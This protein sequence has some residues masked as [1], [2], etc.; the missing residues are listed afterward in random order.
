VELLAFAGVLLAVLGLIHLYLRK[1]LIRDTTVAGRLRQVG[2]GC[3]S[4]S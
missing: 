2:S 4:Y 1:R 3:S